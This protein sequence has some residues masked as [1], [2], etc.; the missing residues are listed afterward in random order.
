MNK[1]TIDR[2]IKESHDYYVSRGDYD[3]PKCGGKGGHDTFHDAYAGPICRNCNGTGIDPNKNI[4]E[5]LSNVVEELMDVK[6]AYRCGR[7]ALSN[8][9]PGYTK[10][11][12]SIW[13]YYNSLVPDEAKSDFYSSLIKDTFE[14]EIADVFIRLFD[15]CG[16]LGIEPYTEGNGEYVSDNIGESILI[17]THRACHA[18]TDGYNNDSHVS[19][20]DISGTLRN[21]IKFYQHHNIPIQKHIEAKL[22]YNRETI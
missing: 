5:L 7:F 12:E 13:S 17:I 21:M 16:Y 19:E 4:G 14:D 11:D 22:A 15:L 2:F 8:K 10:E 18:Y 1:E 20:D 9:K 6:K 3:C